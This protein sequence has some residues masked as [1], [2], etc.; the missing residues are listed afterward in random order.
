MCGDLNAFEWATAWI[1]HKEP[2]LNK[3]GFMYM[4]S[5][6]TDASKH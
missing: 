3:V 2:P 4:L 5:G 6:R 1:N